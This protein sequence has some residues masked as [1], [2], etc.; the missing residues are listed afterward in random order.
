MGHD[1]ASG[2]VWGAKTAHERRDVR[3][4][5]LIRAA[6][7]VYGATGYRQATVKAVCEQAGLTERYFYE[8]FANSEELLRA[9]FVQVTRGLLARVRAASEEG[10]ATGLD[11]VRAGLRVYFDA[12]REH[13]A[14][15]R[16]FLIEVASVSPATEALVSASLDEFGALLVE[17]LRRA[18]A[19]EASPLLL[20]GV[21]G[22]GLHIAKAWISD[23]CA[24]STEEAAEAALRLYSVLA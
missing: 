13:P 6:I 16:V 11:R 10:G 19:S 22:G 15:A 14:A 23:G 9:C 8:S 1:L 3:R 2:R 4:I 7:A 12:L 18:P 24:A 5:A 20:R 17:V 21:V